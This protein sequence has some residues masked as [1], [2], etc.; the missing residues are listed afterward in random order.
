M[1]KTMPFMLPHQRP[2]FFLKAWTFQLTRPFLE[3]MLSNQSRR[4]TDR[5]LPLIGM[6]ASIGFIRI[7]LNCKPD[8]SAAILQQ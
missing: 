6:A 7:T 2:S 8:S 5:A 1:S 4:P 3:G